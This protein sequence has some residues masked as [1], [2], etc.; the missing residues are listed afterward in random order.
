MASPTQFFIIAG[1]PKSGTTTLA[2]WF[3]TRADMQLHP[4]KEPRFFTDFSETD[5]VGPSAE[6]FTSGIVTDEKEYLEAFGDCC[7]ETWAIDAST[8]YLWCEASAG[9]IGK[10]SKKYRTKVVCILRDPIKRVI[11]EYQHTIRDHMQ[12]DSLL[13]SLENEDNRFEKN[14]HPLFFHIRRS[15]YLK[16]IN[17]YRDIMGDDLLV[18]DY[19]ELF[20]PDQLRQKIETFLGIPSIALDVPERHNVSMT[21]RNQNMAKAMKSPK[22]KA[23]ARAMVPKPLR[24]TVRKASNFLLRTSYLPSP[25]ELSLLDGK[26]ATEIS[27]C[28]ESDLIPT[29]SWG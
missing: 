10:W 19:K 9:M 4:T 2:N 6:G 3:G 13:H 8:D 7:S 5:W 16:Q 27:A 1:A 28:R 22:V 11:S 14:W 20:E 21:Y 12:T 18:L 23:L 25:A 29:D 26:L 17:R 15:Q 24:A